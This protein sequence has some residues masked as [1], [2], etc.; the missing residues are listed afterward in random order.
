MKLYHG[1]NQKINNIDLS[2]SKPYKDFGKG[3]Y[4]S[5]SI[6]QAIEM[7]EFK[8]AQLGGEPIVTTF[9]FDKE[10]LLSSNLDI[11]EF[12]GYTEEWID[13]IIDNRGGTNDKVC[14][15][16]FG[17]IAD[18]KVG[19]QLRRY[20]DNDINKQE[21]I[22]RLRYYKGVTYQYFFGSEKALRYLN[23]I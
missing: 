2:K 12:K 15:F 6:Q 8:A 10:A 23:L 7:A 19:R 3:F 16:V 21:L 17:P 9:E 5:D 14:D 11:K 18:D 20:N 4:L 1:S 13:F 22:E